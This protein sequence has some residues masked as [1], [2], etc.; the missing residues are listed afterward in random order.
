MYESTQKNGY[1]RKNLKESAY[2]NTGR[3]KNV[4]RKKKGEESLCVRSKINQ[5]LHCSRKT[6]HLLSRISNVGVL[7]R[8]IIGKPGAQANPDGDQ[9]GSFTASSAG[10][11]YEKSLLK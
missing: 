3:E 4:E 5:G 1:R 8:S 7:K 2:L 11:A 9:R 10:C 6:S